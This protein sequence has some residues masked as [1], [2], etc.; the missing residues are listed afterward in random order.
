MILSRQ[1]LI[2][3]IGA[4]SES[5]AKK[6]IYKGTD[7]G[8]WIKFEDDGITVGSI[9]EGSDAEITKPK[10]EFPFEA[11]QFWDLLEEVNYEACE[12]WEEANYESE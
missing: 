5:I 6:A 8:A 10:L 7:C 2:E 9:V 11:R 3:E 1:E 4:D 12:A